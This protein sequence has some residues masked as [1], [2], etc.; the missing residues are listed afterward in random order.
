MKVNEFGAELDKN[1]YA[2]SIMGTVA[3]K[4]FLCEN[5]THTERHEVFGASN[6]T[7]SKAL[8]LWVNL[9]PHCHREGSFAVHSNKDIAR[10]LKELAQ[11]CAMDAY[12]WSRDEFRTRFGKNYV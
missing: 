12:G 11:F 10:K 2:P 3:G 4:C 1:G 6:R 8:G 9:C 7:K 5:M